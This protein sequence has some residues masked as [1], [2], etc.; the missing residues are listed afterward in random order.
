MLVSL[1]VS[2]AAAA[3]FDR[4]CKEEGP[5]QVC[6]NK[7]DSNNYIEINYKKEGSL[8]KQGFDSIN[9]WYQINSQSGVNYN[10]GYWGNRGGF[11]GATSGVNVNAS[12]KY[13]VQ[14][15]FFNKDSTWDSK[16]GKNYKFVF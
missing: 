14:V 12:N 1:L 15:A 6:L 5:A 4:V 11:Y 10:M 16:F 3:T 13:E 7:F 9:V 2:I 8:L